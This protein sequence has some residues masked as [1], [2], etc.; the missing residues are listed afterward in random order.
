MDVH[1]Q[2]AQEEKGI[3]HVEELP[4]SFREGGLSD[5]D[6]DNTAS[7][8]SNS[9]QV[10]EDEFSDRVTLKTWIVIVVCT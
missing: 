8:L 7:S 4:H 2:A 6:A 10:R 5:R 9:R 3:Q 1:Q